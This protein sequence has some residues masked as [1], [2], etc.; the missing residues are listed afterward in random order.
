M[1]DLSLFGKWLSDQMTREELNIVG[2]AELVGVS[3]A[4]VYKWMRGI[5]TPRDSNVKRLAHALRVDPVDVYRAVTGTMQNSRRWPEDVHA[6]IE[7]YLA[8]SP[9]KRRAFRSIV[10]D[11]RELEEADEEEPEREGEGIGGR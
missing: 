2:L 4:T 8:L 9:R 11:A 6:L 5:A 7:D 3:H 10:R 1:T